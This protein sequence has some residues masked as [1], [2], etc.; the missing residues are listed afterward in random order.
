[1]QGIFIIL[2]F[3]L[4]GTALARLTGNVIPG[5]IIGMVLMF[6]ALKT[7]A[8]KAGH[9]KKASDFLLDNMM[10]FFVPVGVG[11]TVSYA[12]VS[13]HLWAMA[14]AALVSTVLV[15]AAVGLAAQHIGRKERRPQGRHNPEK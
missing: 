5:S 15:L 3:Y 7:K 12:L 2:V 1:M 8:L 14:V 6:A 11:L 9:V 13:G 10:L 4:A